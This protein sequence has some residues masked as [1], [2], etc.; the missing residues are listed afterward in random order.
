MFFHVP[1]TAAYRESI[2][3]RDYDGYDDYDENEAHRA[4]S[5]LLSTVRPVNSTYPASPLNRCQEDMMEEKHHESLRSSQ[6][7]ENVGIYKRLGE[8]KLN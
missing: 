6:A 7:E 3:K 5:S 1:P 4:P 2:E 8:G